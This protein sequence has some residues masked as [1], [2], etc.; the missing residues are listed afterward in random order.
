MQGWRPPP[1][2]SAR[3]APW[4]GASRRFALVNAP[5]GTTPRIGPRGAS[6]TPRDPR[7]RAKLPAPRRVVGKHRIETRDATPGPV[8]DGRNA[9]G[10]RRRRRR[11]EPPIQVAR[12]RDTVPIVRLRA[13]P[14]T[15]GSRLFSRRPGLRA[16]VD[17]VPCPP[18][19]LAEDPWTD[20]VEPGANFTIWYGDIGHGVVEVVI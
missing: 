11:R 17:S 6:R 4:L 18:R 12:R 9:A 1:W 14:H 2:G 13:R 5:R 3:G 7:S 20:V 19:F 10:I 8:C 15:R 16:R